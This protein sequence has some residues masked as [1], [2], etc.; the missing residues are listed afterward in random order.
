VLNATSIYNIIR[1]YSINYT[2]AHTNF[3]LIASQMHRYLNS[4]SSQ[5]T[6]CLHETGL[7]TGLTCTLANH[8]QSCEAVPVCQ[9]VLINTSG[10]TGVFGLGIMKFEKQYNLLNSSEA[11]F[12]AA[13]QGINRTNDFLGFQQLWLILITF[14]MLRARF[15]R[16]LY[17]LQTTLRQAR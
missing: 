1:N 11:S 3:T 14:Q 12:F 9:A 6:D 15:T 8:C 7:D 4:S 13:L 10:P 16:T 5:V 2:L 17:S